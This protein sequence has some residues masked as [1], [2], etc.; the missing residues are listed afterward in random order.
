MIKQAQGKSDFREQGVSQANPF[1]LKPLF[2]VPSPKEYKY[3][4]WCK[5]SIVKRRGQVIYELVREPDV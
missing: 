5:A 1:F 4:C 2:V 3:G